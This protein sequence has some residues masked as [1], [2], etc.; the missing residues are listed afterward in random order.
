MCQRTPYAQVAAVLLRQD[1][2]FAGSAKPVAC[3]R[4]QQQTLHAITLS[5]LSRTLFLLL[6]CSAQQPQSTT[7]PAHQCSALATPAWC[8]NSRICCGVTPIQQALRPSPTTA[9]RRKLTAQRCLQWSPGRNWRGSP[10]GLPT[11]V[12]TKNHHPH[13][14]LGAKTSRRQQAGAC[15]AHV[16]ERRHPQAVHRKHHKARPQLPPTE[17]RQSGQLIMLQGNAHSATSHADDTTCT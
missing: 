1:R 5:A 11:C 10:R 8:V 13:S 7:L 6:S 9:S 15:C 2:P 4:R 17:P 16:A 14:L 12:T 3:S